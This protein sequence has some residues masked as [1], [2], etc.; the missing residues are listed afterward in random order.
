MAV[1]DGDVVLVP[2]GYHPCAACHGYDLYYLNVMAGPKR[3]WKILQRAGA[4]VAD[5]GVRTSEPSPKGR[6]WLRSNRWLQRLRNGE[7]AVRRHPSPVAFGD[8][9]SSGEGW[10][11]QMSN[12]HLYEF[13]CIRVERHVALR[14]AATAM[15]RV[16]HCAADGERPHRLDRHMQPLRRDQ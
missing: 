8:T 13:P 1:E 14:R 3:T 16:D 4:R 5:E 6:R 12:Q 11:R 15:I 10:A 7:T 9:L 2:K